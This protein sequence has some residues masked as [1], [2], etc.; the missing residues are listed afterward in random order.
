MA[1][2][3]RLP[4]LGK[5]RGGPMIGMLGRVLFYVVLDVVVVTAV[6]LVKDGMSLNALLKIISGNMITGG[7]VG[8]VAYLFWLPRYRAA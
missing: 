4:L 7:L 1:D 6:V 5:G 3:K 8:L 2:A